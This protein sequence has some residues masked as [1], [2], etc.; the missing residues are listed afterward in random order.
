MTRCATKYPAHL[1]LLVCWLSG[2]AVVRSSLRAAGDPPPNVVIIL[3]DDQ[4][5][6]D[7][8]VFGA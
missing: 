3:T 6:A 4:G 2:L 5:Y 1:A 8:G 7:V